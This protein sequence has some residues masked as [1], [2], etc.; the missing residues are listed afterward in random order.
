MK[1]G[2]REI[3]EGIDIRTQESIRT[4][5]EKENYKY[6]GI[7][8]ANTIKKVKMREKLRKEYI[9]W[10]RKLLKINHCSRKL[11][12]DS[13]YRKIHRTILKMD[14]VGTQVNEQ[15]DDK[16]EDHSLG[17]TAKRY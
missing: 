11:I 8:E 10:I 5:G 13:F 3:T 7:L 17:L 14:K 16:V 4:L 12:T 2:K 15:E 6:L 1:S 9:R